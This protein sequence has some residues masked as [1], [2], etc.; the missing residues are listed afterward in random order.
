ML[1]DAEWAFDASSLTLIVS[2]LDKDYPQNLDYSQFIGTA[3]VGV[4]TFGDTVVESQQP[5][6]ELRWVTSAPTDSAL[7]LLRDW[8]LVTGY[9][10]TAA[11]QFLQLTIGTL[12]SGGLIRLRAQVD[13]E[14][15]AVFADLTRSLGERWEVGL[16]GRLFRQTTEADIST[17]VI[18]AEGLST[19]LLPGLL[20]QVIGALPGKAAV[21]WGA[22]WATSAK[23]CSTPSSLCAGSTAMTC[24]CSPRR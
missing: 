11:D 19:V 21:P 23:R 9:F 1:A 24:Q 2:H 6:A 5:S 15:H 3:S 12:P 16:G 22:M 7:W 4:G 17:T 18:A 13:A 10:Y 8:S 20:P 14:E